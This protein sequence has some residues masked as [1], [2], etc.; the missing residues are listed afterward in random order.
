MEYSLGKI[1]ETPKEIKYIK[2]KHLKENL[3]ENCSV[4]YQ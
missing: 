4:S 2:V 1:C 3:I